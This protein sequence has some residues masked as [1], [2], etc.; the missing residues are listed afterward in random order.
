VAPRQL[1][2]IRETQAEYE[3]RRYATDPAFRQMRQQRT[4]MR[5]RG[6]DAVPL[7]GQEALFEQFNGLCAYCPEPATTW[8]H[9]VPVSAGGTTAP[10][11]IV[12]ACLSCNSRKG[13]LDI[14]DFIEKH[15]VVISDALDSAIALALEWGQLVA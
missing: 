13:A 14:H 3:R 2:L 11:N 9:I 15:G 6:V 4:A 12:P 1:L 10:G 8:D 7:A 5:R